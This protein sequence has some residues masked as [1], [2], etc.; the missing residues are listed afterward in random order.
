MSMDFLTGLAYLAIL[1]LVIAN[2]LIVRRM[3][4]EIRDAEDE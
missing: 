3:K 2:V 1:V 4:I